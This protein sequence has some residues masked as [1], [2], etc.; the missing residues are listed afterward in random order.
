VSLFRPAPERRADRPTDSLGELY[1]RRQQPFDAGG[2][3][4]VDQAMR[5]GAVWAC[6]DLI[7]RTI[8]TLPVHEYERGQGAPVQLPPSPLLTKPDGDVSRTVWLYQVLSSLLTTGNTFGLVDPPMTVGWPERIELLDASRITL[9]RDGRSGPVRW[10]VDQKPVEKW[11]AGPLWHVPAWVRAGSPIGLSPIEHAAL[12]IGIG[13]NAEKFGAQWFR[14]GAVPTGMLLSDKTVNPETA[15]TVKR[16]WL[17]ALMGNREP[18]VMGD[19]W[20]YEQIQVTAEESQFLATM[21]AT[22]ADIASY[23][24]IPPEE[25]G[26]SSGSSMTYS[27]IESRSLNM[28]TYTFGPWIVR[29]EE[30]LTALRPEGR[31]CKIN[32]DAFVRV[33][34]TTR[35]KAYESAIRTGWRSPDEVRE[36]EDLP[37][38]PDGKGDRFLWPPLR[39]QLT[40]EELLLGADS[41]ADDEGVTAPAGPGAASGGGTAGRA[42]AGPEGGP[43]EI[44]RALQ[45]VYLAVTSKVI[46][47]SEAREIVNRLGAGLSVELPPELVAELAPGPQEV[48]P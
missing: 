24:G 43:L 12:K 30:A 21:S 20:K 9:S 39:Q 41:G 40:E 4:D 26:G 35:M 5:L 17:D 3:I 42:A 6:V 36:K 10:Y 47:K 19:G 45:Q 32:A 46:T 8:S 22:K 18:V 29:L 7:A 16:R 2:R 44:T 25:I 31:Y 33:D 14:D 28:L 1:R 23:Y 27:N 34:T 11:P 15:K 13:L 48:S 38:I 37:P